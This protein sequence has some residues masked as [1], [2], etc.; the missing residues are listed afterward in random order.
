MK[1]RAS[2]AL[3]ALLAGSTALFVYTLAPTLLWGDDAMFQQALAQ[4]GLTNHPV[5][6]LMARLFV[7]L[8][9][10]DLA[11]RAN[12]ISAVCSAGAVSALFL[13]ARAL[14]G[15]LRAA[16]ASGMVLSVSHTFWLQSVRAEV[17]TLHLLLF[18]T[19]LWALLRWRRTPGKWPWLAFGLAVWLLGAAN[20]LLLTLAFPGGVWLVASAMPQHLRKRGLGAIAALVAS[21]ALLILAVAPSFFTQVVPDSARV[22]LATFRL[23]PRWLLIHMVLLVYQAPL[24]FVLAVP[25]VR[26]LWQRDRHVTIG[27]ALI[28]VPTAA[29]AATHGILEGYV[30]YLPVYALLALAIGLGSDAAMRRWPWPGWLLAALAVLSLQVGT[31]RLTPE[32]LDRFAPG[33]IS[34]RDL[35]GRPA[36]RF[37]LWPPKR[38]YTGARWFVEASLD[39]LPADAILVADWTP[40]AALRY[41]QDVD[42]RRADVLLIQPDA[43]DNLCLRTLRENKGQRPIFLANADPRYYP[44]AEIERDFDVKPLGPIFALTPRET[45]P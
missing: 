7:R 20:H 32:V 37:F 22:V 12:L 1:L 10:G 3:S 30:F 27:L 44:M 43:A 4:G 29:F 41:G 24:L 28:A 31:Y 23:S 14:G 16:L 2:A 38:G 35:P 42:G 8:P 45:G 34:A 33:L 6:G 26:G 5:W 13:V 39:V 25:G 36:N 15:S 40:F 11:F 19:G 17:Y 9:L 18:L 21:G